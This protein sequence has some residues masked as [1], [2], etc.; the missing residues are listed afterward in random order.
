VG[1]PGFHHGTLDSMSNVR[2]RLLGKKP[3]G[4]IGSYPE[5]E[6]ITFH[7]KDHPKSEAS[8]AYCSILSAKPSIA[9]STRRAT[10]LKD[11]TV[12]RISVPLDS[13][14]SVSVALK[15]REES[16]HHLYVV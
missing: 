15:Q 14:M 8:T 9:V 3:W 16:E 1:N 7:L 4:Y 5:E 10:P 6:F 11:F 12:D 2:F 13:G